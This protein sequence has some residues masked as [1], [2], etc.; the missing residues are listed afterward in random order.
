MIFMLVIKKKDV[1]T[2][3]IYNQIFNEPVYGMA[4]GFLKHTGS[5][6]RWHGVT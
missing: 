2:S 3:G 5:L 6:W 4:W 1:T